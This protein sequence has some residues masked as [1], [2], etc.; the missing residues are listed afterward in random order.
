MAYRDQHGPVL[1]SDLTIRE[2][3]EEGRPLSK[4]KK[5][6]ARQS[7]EPLVLDCSIVM[8]WY[9]VDESD[10]YADRVARQLPGRRAF[11]P[12]NWPLEVANSLIVGEGR[13]RSNQAKRGE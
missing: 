4:R 9:F 1:G 6:V 11:V 10:A 13:K 5:E 2:L 8:A 3:I 12:A 7:E